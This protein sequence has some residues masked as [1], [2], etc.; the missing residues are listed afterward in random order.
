M[1]FTE[2]ADVK[3]ERFVQR[4]K[5]ALAAADDGHD[6]DDGPPIVRHKLRAIRRA[7]GRAKLSTE[8]LIRLQGRC[9]EA[10]LHTS[11]RLDGENVILDDPIRFKAS[12]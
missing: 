11:P 6:E 5:D 3:E 8:F 7:C 1:A 4:V 12:A 2:S 10:G 9:D